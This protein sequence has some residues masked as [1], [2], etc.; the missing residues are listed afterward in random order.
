MYRKK[1]S[2]TTLILKEYLEREIILYLSKYHFAVCFSRVFFENRAKTPQNISLFTLFNKETKLEKYMF[3]KIISSHQAIYSKY[4][5]TSL[6]DK[7][8]AVH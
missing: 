8:F 1:E 4:R 6:G 2:R 3:Q 7:N 5:F